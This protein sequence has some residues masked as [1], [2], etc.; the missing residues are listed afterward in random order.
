[1]LRRI[2]EPERDGVTGHCR[3]LHNEEL[4]SLYTS[5]NNIWVIKSRMMRWA[6][7]VEKRVHFVGKPDG[8]RPLRR[9][10]RR[11]EGNVQMELKEI[12]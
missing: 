6:E 10:R 12:G 5:P 7:H 11:W 3:I 8:K 9:P 1:V 2:L 4:H